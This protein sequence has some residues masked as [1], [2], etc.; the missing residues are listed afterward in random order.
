MPTAL[1]VEDHLGVQELYTLYLEFTGFSVRV[2]ATGTAAIQECL[3]TR[4]DVLVLDVR[5]PDLTGLE[6][7]RSF[8]TAGLRVN[9]I[10]VSGHMDAAVRAEATR[11]GAL[12]CLEK[13]FLL[14]DLKTAL[15]PVLEP[16]LVA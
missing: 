8:Q 3:R 4:P 11:L 10:V 12:A 9:A 2:A 16:A 13:P 14:E 15:R 1:V 7:L 6:V 5:L